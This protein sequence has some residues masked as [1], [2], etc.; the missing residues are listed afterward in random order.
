[1]TTSVRPE[2]YP[3]DDTAAA[4]P[5]PWTL[6]LRTFI[7]WQIVRFAWINL[8]MLRVIWRSHRTRLT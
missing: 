3:V 1:M 5:T 4:L 2:R 7:P 6:F 8:R